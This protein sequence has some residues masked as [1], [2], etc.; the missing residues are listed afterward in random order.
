MS[1][2]NRNSE[3]YIALEC[4]DLQANAMAV[5]STGTYVLLAG[6]RYLAIR[7]LE[8]QYESILKFPRQSKYDVGAAEWNPTLHHKELCVIS[9]NQR[10]E[11]LTW[12]NDE[13]TQTHSLRA[14]TRVITDLNWHKFDPNLLASCS[15]DTFIHLW[16]IRDPKRPTLSLSAIAE[17]SQV[18]WN[19][20]SPHLVA[21]AH[22]GDIKI[23]DQRKGTAPVQYVAAHLAKIYGL[24][25]SP[26]LEN[27]ICSSS[28]DN[29][30]KFFDISNPR[31][32]DYTLTTNAPV[33]RARHTP[34]GEG[35]VTVVV[36]QLRRGENSL[37]LWNISNK[38][39][40]VHTF[41][42]H[43]DVVLD[44][45]W[46]KRRSGDTDFQL[47]TWSKDQTL[48]VW[49]IEPFLQKLCGHEADDLKDVDD[50]SDI[51]VV[52]LPKK[53]S[54]SVQPLQQ[55]FSLLNVHIPNLEVKKM[56]IVARIVNVKVTVNNLTVNLEA[57]FPNTYPHGVPP[58]FQVVTGSNINDIIKTQLL[59]TL[60]H[61][62]QQRVS[63]NR[64]CLEPCLRQMVTTLEQL[65]VDVEHDRIYERPY[66]DPVN[67]L[68]GYNDAYI[69]FP[70]TSG[71]KFCSVGTLVC[72]SRPLHTRRISN[73]LEVTTPR[74]LSALENIF[75]KRSNDYMTVSAYY[76][77]RQRSRAKHNFS[78]FSKAVVHI[79]DALG[80]FFV[81]RQLAEEYI[82]D[83]DVGTICKHNAAAAAVVGR[84]DLV[85]A[86][87][88]A[89][90]VA[91][92][93]QADEE[94]SWSVHP[95]GNQLMQSLIT[96]YATQSD[97]QMAAMLCCIFGKD[98]EI[99]IRKSSLKL[100]LS[101]AHLVPGKKWLKSGN[102]PYHTI[103]P[104]DVIADGWVIPMLRT[105]RSTSLDNLRV[106]ELVQLVPQRNASS[107][108]YE[109]YKFAYA[110]TLY[111]WGLLYNR[112]EVIKYMCNLPEPHRGV[113]FLTD[114]KNCL[115]PAKN[116]ICNTCKNFS[117]NCIVCHLS[118]RGSANCCMICGHGGHTSCL[119][120]WFSIKN[121]CLT[122]CG[123][124]CLV[125]TAGMFSS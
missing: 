57:T 79:Y 3:Y 46:R 55:E 19:K 21:T 9:S 29:T 24:D 75:A 106:E 71:A 83:G 99:S 56:D 67:G 91:G 113:E 98:H 16:D 8:E 26:T 12:K 119:S 45:D 35:L 77:Q 44:F 38:T 76:F 39:T 54:P 122:G 4:K 100:L 65:S 96:H 17:A 5:D 62:A 123:C 111:R 82:L 25:W 84:G 78:K 94:M 68:G 51:E 14:H 37:L 33:W 66:I 115:K 116:C 88:L 97:I 32:S 2:I 74:A 105:T 48:L 69:P 13:L 50:A 107:A 86:W 125:D 28:Q 103:P 114:C 70:R 60:N 59:Q 15:A 63:K 93:Q 49:N 73:K 40:P 61:L 18:R 112:A 124:H 31:R 121:Y 85:Q 81:N 89:E 47:I 43:R 42:G 87:T 52:K 109:Y 104:A 58:T 1:I 92:P 7:N 102:S 80:L 6:R 10:L 36:P 23:W 117:L 120:E 90:L 110:E 11:V 72:F 41:V 20:I 30:V 27:Q 108:L 95:F 53:S 22:E 34:F 118:V 101:P 64:T